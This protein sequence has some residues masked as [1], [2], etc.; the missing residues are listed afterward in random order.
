ME[1]IIRKGYSSAG[2]LILNFRMFLQR[3]CP[4]CGQHA[5]DSSPFK[6][7]CLRLKW[8][9]LLTDNIFVLFSSSLKILKII[10]GKWWQCDSCF[11]SGIYMKCC[12][13]QTGVYDPPVFIVDRTAWSYRSGCGGW[14]QGSVLPGSGCRWSGRGPSEWLLIHSASKW[15]VCPW[16]QEAFLNLRTAGGKCSGSIMFDPERSAERSMAL[17]SSR[18]FPGHR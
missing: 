18:T 6:I 12:A 16:F 15:W 9:W 14:F 1:V 5:P 11:L 17:W 13:D 2:S 8:S 10:L 4:V 7:F 3:L